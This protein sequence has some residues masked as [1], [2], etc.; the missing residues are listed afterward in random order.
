[1]VRKD[2][3]TPRGKKLYGSTVKIGELK[4]SFRNTY[5]NTK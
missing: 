4:W 1:V 3:W 2:E 5:A